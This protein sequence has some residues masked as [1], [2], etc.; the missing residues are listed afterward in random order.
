MCR[1]GYFLIHEPV[2]KPKQ[3]LPNGKFQFL[4]KLFKTYNHSEHDNHIDLSST[5]QLFDSHNGVIQ[6]INFNASILRT[7]ISRIFTLV[8]KIGKSERAWKCLIAAD[9]AFINL[10]CSKPNRFGPGGI[11]IRL[12][13]GLPH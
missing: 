7:L 6:D 1:G 4:H 11:F 5:L 8:P 13:K 10:F 2:E 12:K 9:K 3:L